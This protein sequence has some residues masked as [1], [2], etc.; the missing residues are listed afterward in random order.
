MS[1][2]NSKYLRLGWVWAD[3][4]NQWE[5]QSSLGIQHHKSITNKPRAYMEGFMGIFLIRSYTIRCFHV[6]KQQPVALIHPVVRNFKRIHC[7]RI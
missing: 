2:S 5:I 3:T 6:N 1:S 7:W 4:I